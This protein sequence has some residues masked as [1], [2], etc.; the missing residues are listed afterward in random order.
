M[1]RRTTIRETLLSIAVL[2]LLFAL[3]LLLVIGLPFFV[4]YRVLLRLAVEVVVSANGR[5]ILLVYSRSPVWQE[6]IERNWLP[7][8]A[9]HA[10]V[11][12]WSD[13]ESWK[14]RPSFAVWVFRH[15]APTKD[16]NPMVIVFPAFRPAKRVG[17]YYAFGDWKHGRDGAL[18]DAEKQLFA[19]LGEVQRRSA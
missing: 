11:L 1:A 12:N 19:H 3:L 16:F 4:V 6:Y 17:F 18:R 9:D 10:M 13:R 2:P 8:L 5:R 14:Q 15:W 7:A